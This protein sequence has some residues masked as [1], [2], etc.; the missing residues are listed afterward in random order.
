MFLFHFLFN[1]FAVKLWPK[2]AAEEME[3]ASVFS[4]FPQRFSPSCCAFLHS[5]F[6]GTDFIPRWTSSVRTPPT[7]PPPPPTPLVGFAQEA[8]YWDCKYSVDA[9]RDFISLS[10]TQQ[11]HNQQQ[12]IYFSMQPRAAFKLEEPKHQCPPPGNFQCCA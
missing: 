6:G 3:V 7:P 9:L 5:C 11:S 10:F 1:E 12:N 4:L 2:A 8:H